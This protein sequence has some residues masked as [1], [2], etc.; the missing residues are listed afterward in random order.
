MTASPALQRRRSWLA[1]CIRALGL[2]SLVPGAV[3]PFLF[4]FGRSLGYIRSTYQG[5][6]LPR[7]DEHDGVIAIWIGVAVGVL[8]IVGAKW[9]AAFFLPGYAPPFQVRAGSDATG[10]DRNLMLW[11]RMMTDARRPWRLLLV[12]SVLLVLAADPVLRC[13]LVVLDP[14]VTSPNDPVSPLTVFSAYLLLLGGSVAIVAG[15]RVW[16]S[17]YSDRR[18]MRRQASLV[19]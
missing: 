5:Y 9:I 17:A 6:L 13:S 18:E 15:G 10:H 7:R 11:M 14:M 19:H 16:W 2:L 1:H 3:A 12:G 4:E 8:L